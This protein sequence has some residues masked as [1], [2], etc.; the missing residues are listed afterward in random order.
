ME[1]FYSGIGGIRQMAGSGAYDKIIISPDVVGDLTWAETSFNTV[2]GEII[3][4]WKIEG[5][6][7]IL[8]VK[9][10]VGC[11]AIVAIPEPDPDKILEGE[12]PVR[13][14]VLVKE[15]GVTSGR[16]QFEIPSGEYIFSSPNNR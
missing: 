6:K 10:P 12:I 13:Q 8:K 14:S 5:N 16:T 3:S 2:H 1:W 7:F 9:I 15:I 11:S 4:N